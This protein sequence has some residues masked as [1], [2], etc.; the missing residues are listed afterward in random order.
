MGRL[1]DGYVES[2]YGPPE[3]KEIVEYSSN[4]EKKVYHPR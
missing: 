2:Y 4:S 1:I 3:L